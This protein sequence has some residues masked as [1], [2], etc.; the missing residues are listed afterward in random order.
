ML[1]GTDCSHRSRMLPHSRDKCS[2][3][4][5]SIGNLLP[6]FLAR[7]MYCPL[8]HTPRP[9]IEFLACVAWLLRFPRNTTYLQNLVQ[10]FLHL[11]YSTFPPGWA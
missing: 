1:R 11:T 2:H 5:L 10:T 4:S 3:L 9:P 6:T 7:V 8:F